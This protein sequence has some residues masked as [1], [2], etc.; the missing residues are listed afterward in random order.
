[1]V[2]NFPHKAGFTNL[3]CSCSF[4]VAVK[5]SFFTVFSDSTVVS[6]SFKRSY[7]RHNT[8]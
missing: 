2:T 6:N 3:S 7:E 5:A 4:P 1:M 8:K